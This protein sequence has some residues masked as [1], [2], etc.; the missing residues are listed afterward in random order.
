MRGVGA[1]PVGGRRSSSSKISFPYAGVWIG[2]A[3]G[4]IPGVGATGSGVICERI[5]SPSCWKIPVTGRRSRVRRIPSIAMPAMIPNGP[6]K[7]TRGFIATAYLRRFARSRAI[8]RFMAALPFF[9]A[10]RR[11]RGAAVFFAFAFL[12]RRAADFLPPLRPAR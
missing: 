10:D 9:A 5:A 8:F 3:V 12:R 1:V 6:P 2:G 7:V 4:L 11:R